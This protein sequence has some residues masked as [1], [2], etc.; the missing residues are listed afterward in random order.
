MS[1]FE[2]IL[3]KETLCNQQEV[4]RLGYHGPQHMHCSFFIKSFSKSPE[5]LRCFAS[6]INPLLISSHLKGFV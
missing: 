2:M 6:F 4:L 3:P 1:V 5:L